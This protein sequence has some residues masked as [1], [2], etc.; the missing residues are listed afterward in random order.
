[1]NAVQSL[2][3]PTTNGAGRDR[4]QLKIWLAERIQ[5]SMSNTGKLTRSPEIVQIA[6]ERFKQACQYAKINLPPEKEDVFFNEVL[7]EIVG[8]GPLE[9]LMRDEFVSDIMVNGPK[10]IFVEK[11][12]KIEEVS[13]EFADDDHVLRVINKIVEPLGRQ[14]NA[15]SP[16]VDARL[17]DGSRVNAVIPPCAI[18][19]PTIAIRKFAKERLE[20]QDLI[21]YGSLNQVMADYLQACVV[22]KL[23]I[24]VSGGT[25]SGKTTLLNV[26][27]SF[28]PEKDR[29]ITIEDAAELSLN[30][31]HVVR[32]ETKTPSHEGDSV[33]TIRNLLIN[34][35]RM[36]PDRIVVGECR[37]GEALDMLQAMNT[38]H[39][40]S[41]TTIHANSPRDSLSRLETLVLMAGMDLPI[42]TVRKQIASAINLVVQLSRMRDG[43]RK[44]I[45]V[46]EIAGTEGDTIVMQDLFKFVDQGE[47][48]GKVLGEFE[49]GG[50]RSQYTDRL[51]IYGFNL[52]PKTFMKT[53][54]ST[55]GDTRR[56]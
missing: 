32:L 5:S 20:I 38:G 41:M 19:G 23:N 43:T 24:V 12:G 56:R 17:P 44:I 4:I 51:K 27:S 46:T 15:T 28:I 35:L 45:Q 36:R 9:Q 39:D 37:G 7:D 31:R 54:P 53:M 40:G 48:N 30:Q 8:L 21:N 1:M 34:S 49:P 13:A 22:S 42:Q 6:Y 25:G 50:L 47:K 10:M 14:V 55:N 29:I 33:V 11:R 52:S 18:D 2:A 16:T 3:I 26:L